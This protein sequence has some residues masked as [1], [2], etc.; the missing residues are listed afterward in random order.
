MELFLDVKPVSKG[1]QGRTACGSSAYRACDKIIDNAGNQHDFSKKGGHVAGGVILPAG[2]PEDLLDRQTLW[3]RHDQKEIRKD[4]QIFREVEVAL[5]NS[6]SYDAAER[7]CVAISCRLAE[8]GMCVQWDIHDKTNEKGERNLHA[9][10]MLSMRDLLPDGTFGKKNRSWN[11]FNG[12]MNLADELRPFA[13]ALM[14]EELDKIG[15]ADRVE[16][17]SFADRGIDRIPTVHIG[18]T[19]CA[20][21][22]EKDILT[23]KVRL[24]QRIR[25]INAEHISYV[26]KLAKYR[27]VRDEFTELTLQDAQDRHLGLDAMIEKADAVGRAPAPVPGAKE[28]IYQSIK[29]INLQAAGVKKDRDRIKKIR[30][31]LYTY[32][33][34]AGDPNIDSEQKDQLEWATSY[35][36]W[37]GIKDF[38]PEGVAKAIEHF[39]E[40]NT[41]CHL[42]QCELKKARSQAYNDLWEIRAR[43]NPRL[44]KQLLH[45]DR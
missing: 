32:K 25:E 35:L 45:D 29:K 38:S 34:L 31:A 16:Y 4:A 14:N 20:M 41:G 42:Q 27:A 26:E 5:H 43:E 9:H 33:N 1:D 11:K 36:K 24:N 17:Q 40:Y 28:E 22:N 30:Q 8:M 44:Q 7:V 6:L 13:A 39:R 19:A 21:M 12:G 10:L 3:Q 23:Y 2:A 37:A 15:V 18:V